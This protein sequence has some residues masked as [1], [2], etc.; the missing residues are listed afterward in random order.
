MLSDVDA[1]A[2]LRRLLLLTRFA[3]VCQRFATGGGIVAGHWE[4]LLP[5]LV[6]ELKAQGPN[7]LD[8][9]VRK[10]WWLTEYHF[11]LAQA[12]NPDTLPLTRVLPNNPIAHVV[13]AK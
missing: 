4:Q 3:F 8:T 12:Q 10:A 9:A 11:H 2:W 13:S 6:A 1:S 5:R 7:A